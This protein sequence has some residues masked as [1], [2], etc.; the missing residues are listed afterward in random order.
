MFGDANAICIAQYVLGRGDLVFEI[1]DFSVPEKRERQCE[2]FCKDTV[3]DV[4]HAVYILQSVTDKASLVCDDEDKEG[5]KERLTA[6][7]SVRIV[8]GM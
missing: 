3:G 4:A 8:S 2:H 6:R 7:P 5:E 1:P